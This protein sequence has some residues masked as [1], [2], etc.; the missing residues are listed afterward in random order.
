MTHDENA[1]YGGRGRKA[2]LGKK[3]SL[4]CSMSNIYKN[5]EPSLHGIV[6]LK[7]AQR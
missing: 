4:M 5:T 1:I 2:T 3:D 7:A 6:D